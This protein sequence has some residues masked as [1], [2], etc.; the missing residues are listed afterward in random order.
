MK[1]KRTTREDILNYWLQ[2]YHNTNV[3]ELIEKH[4]KEV[5]ENPDWFKL[6]PVTDA[7][8]DEWYNWAI[9]T[10][11]KEYKFSKEMTRK[12]FVFMYLD[13]APNIKKEEKDETL[14]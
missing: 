6:Y 3:Q 13:T 10:L 5:L 9:S 1:K 4:P 8:H 2:K 7:Q 11:S 12:Q 14:T